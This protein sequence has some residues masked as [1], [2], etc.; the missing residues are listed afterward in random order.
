MPT[1]EAEPDF[2]DFTLIIRKGGRYGVLAKSGGE[3]VPITIARPDE[4]SMLI[5]TVPPPSSIVE[6]MDRTFILAAGDAAEADARE[7]RDEAAAI[8]AGPEAADSDD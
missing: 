7:A 5:V 1:P 2:G 8:E 6:A 4:H 3:A